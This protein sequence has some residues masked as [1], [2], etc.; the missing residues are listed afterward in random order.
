MYIEK[1]V[2]DHLRCFEHAEVEFCH[3]GCTVPDTKW[4]NV[5]VLLGN[6]GAGK[7]TLL[8]AAVL[9]VLAPVLESSSGYV[10]YRMVRQA[11]TVDSPGQSSVTARYALQV[12]QDSLPTET[13]LDMK[14]MKLLAYGQHVAAELERYE[15]G[16]EVLRAYSVDPLLRRLLFD[17]QSAIFIVAYGAGRRVEVA[18]IVDAALRSKSRNYRYQRVAS[19]FEDHYSLMPLAAWLPAFRK[20]NPGRHKQVVN[21]INR[22]LPPECE[23]LATPRVS[24]NDGDEYF[25]RLHAVEVPFAALSDGYRAYIGWIADMLYHLC[26][27]CPKGHKLVEMSGVVLVDEIDLHLHPE[28]QRQVLPVLARALPRLQ[29]I[30]STHS[31]IV[32]GTVGRGNLYRL[33]TGPDGD[34]L[35]SHPELDIYGMSADQI[36]LSS[37][38]GL[39]STRAEGKL[40]ELEKLSAR[41]RQGDA[42]AAIDYLKALTP[43]APKARRARKTEHGGSR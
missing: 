24:G 37:Y 23:L 20:E 16:V 28:W 19:L 3:P 6:N 5:N 42:R 29:F 17:R 2:I 32:A 18:D 21:L 25:F 4:P 9:A 10:P 1:L 30:V 26:H 35:V 14:L 15:S 39:D 8:R 12:W 33:D 7:T 34:A 13:A 43:A 41:V 36:L 22:V 40:S 38:F 11:G 27:G 31:P